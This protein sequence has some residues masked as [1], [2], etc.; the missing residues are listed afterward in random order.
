MPPGVR[1]LS[2]R[3]NPA[4]A[5]A[6]ASQAAVERLRRENEALM[7]RLQE[8]EDAGVRAEEKG[9]G[10]V[11]GEGAMVP[12][13]SW[14][15]VNREKVRLEEEL[16]QKEKRLKRLQEVCLS[17]RRPPPSLYSRIT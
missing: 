11:K 12:R 14:E 1:V 13:E 15:V 4:Q 5:W 16:K 6:D 2:L 3:E 17:P 7:R 9:E 10:E 8:L